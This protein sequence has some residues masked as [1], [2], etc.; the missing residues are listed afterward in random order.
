[1]GFDITATVATGRRDNFEP[2]EIASEKRQSRPRD[3]IDLRQGGPYPAVRTRDYNMLG[4]FTS[5]D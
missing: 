4:H 3:G 2:T 1:M 5:S